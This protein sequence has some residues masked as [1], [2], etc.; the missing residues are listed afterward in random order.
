MNAKLES[1]RCS[2][3][4]AHA[5]KMYSGMGS[6]S[7]DP[8]RLNDMADLSS[9]LRSGRFAKAIQPRTLAILS[10]ERASKFDVIFTS[11]LS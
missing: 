2:T 6:S 3:I 7:F 9:T 1:L 8:F 5:S 4:G 10:Q 11:I